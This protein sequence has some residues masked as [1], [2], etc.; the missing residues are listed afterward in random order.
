MSESVDGGA[1]VKKTAA[2]IKTYT[3][4]VTDN[5][6]V[7]PGERYLT[8]I[9]DCGKVPNENDYRIAKGLTQGKSVK[10]IVGLV[11]GN[12]AFWIYMI[13]DF[14]TTYLLG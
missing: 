13:L 1:V 10:F 6:P 8:H 4:D 12:A 3:D 11:V 7:G 5:D 9:Y 14:V 2:S